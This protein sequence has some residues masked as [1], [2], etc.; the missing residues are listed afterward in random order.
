[1]QDNCGERP[2]LGA[3]LVEQGTVSGGDVERALDAQAGSGTRLGEILIDLGLICRPQL[4]RAVAGQSGVEL[5]E[6][7]GYGT[8][9]RAAIE[10]RHGYRRAF[11]LQSG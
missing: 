7:N 1:M 9:L 5:E 4:D 6:E 11:G 2:L 3:V 8:G 10:R